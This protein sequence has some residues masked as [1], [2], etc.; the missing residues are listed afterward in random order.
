MKLKNKA[1]MLRARAKKQKNLTPAGKKSLLEKA[2][3][4]DAQ[5]KSRAGKKPAKAFK[6]GVAKRDCDVCKRLS[7][8]TDAEIDAGVR[9]WVE[10]FGGQMPSAGSAK[11]VK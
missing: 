1:A 11:P 5:A 7:E 9:Y 10:R 6:R 2:R 4:L 8:V 3:A